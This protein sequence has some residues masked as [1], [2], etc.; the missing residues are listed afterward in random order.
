MELF[1]CVWRSGAFL[2][3]SLVNM[4]KS[5]AC[6][7]VGFALCVAVFVAG[8]RTLSHVPVRQPPVDSLVAMPAILLLGLYGGDRYLAAN[9][10]NARLLGVETSQEREGVLY[11]RMAHESVSALNPCHEDN[12]YVANAILG[13]GGA[14]QEAFRILERATVC[15]FWDEW[16]PF[17]YAYGKYY[18]EGDIKTASRLMK[19]AADRKGENSIYFQRLATSLLSKTFQDNRQALLFLQAEQK[20]VRDPRLRRSLAARIARL[21]GLIRL[22]DAAKEFEKRIGHKISKPQDLLVAGI[23]QSFPRDPLGIGYTFDDETGRFGLR[24]LQP[25][26]R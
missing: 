7:W 6:K 14:P 4:M 18:F 11:F 12:Y 24:A 5:I 17:Y 2:C 20:Q 8:T 23:L 1:Y 16:P 25:N 13:W 9:F 3:G 15:R 10:E 21:E 26:G 19:V 22:E